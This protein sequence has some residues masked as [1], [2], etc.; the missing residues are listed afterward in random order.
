ML[1]AN[2]LG[3]Q[4]YS[5]EQVVF[6]GKSGILATYSNHNEVLHHP[7]APIWHVLCLGWPSRP[8]WSDLYFSARKPKIRA[9]PVPKPNR[10]PHSLEVANPAKRTLNYETATP[11]QPPAIHSK[12]I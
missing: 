3:K 11:N 2:V 1:N 7:M 6:L 9:H 4:A 12:T 10:K 8:R 5:F